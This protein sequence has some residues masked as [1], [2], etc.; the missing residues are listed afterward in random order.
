MTDEEDKRF[1][2]R[3]LIV[4]KDQYLP[5]HDHPDMFVISKVMK[6]T[7]EMTSFN[8]KNDYAQREIPEEIHCLNRFDKF[9]K[10]N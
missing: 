5:I 3:A 1:S 9:E 8:F 7:L 10:S 4:P 2:L 6:G